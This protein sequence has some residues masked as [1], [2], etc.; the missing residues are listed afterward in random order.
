MVI[1]FTFVLHSIFTNKQ[2]DFIPSSAYNV[3]N[4]MLLDI[5]IKKIQVYCSIKNKSNHLNT[6]FINFDKIKNLISYFYI[7]QPQV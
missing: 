6:I 7:I 1:C 5:F 4:L 2:V 3:I